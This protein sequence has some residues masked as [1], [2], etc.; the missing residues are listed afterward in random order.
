MLL[1][2]YAEISQGQYKHV[3]FARCDRLLWELV[4]RAVLHFSKKK[5][6]S[7]SAREKVKIHFTSADFNVRLLGKIHF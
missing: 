2:I 3:Q 4:V 7:S 5:L 1:I 6:L